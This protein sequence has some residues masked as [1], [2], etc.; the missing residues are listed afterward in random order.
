MYMQQSNIHDNLIRYEIYIYICLYTHCGIRY[1]I[2]LFHIARENPLQM[3]VDSWEN[4]ISIGNCPFY[5]KESEGI[6]THVI[7][8][9]PK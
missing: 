5:L 6:Y 3:E 1:T 7:H 9:N 8:Y 4:H 2:W